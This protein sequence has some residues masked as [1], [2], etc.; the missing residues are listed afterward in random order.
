[1]EDHP[2]LRFS[3]IDG[4]IRRLVV[5][6]FPPNKFTIYPN[7]QIA[8][9]DINF[10]YGSRANSFWPLFINYFELDLNIYH[11]QTHLE[12]FKQYLIGNSWGVTDVALRVQRKH[13]TALDSDLIVIEYNLDIIREI[14]NNNPI[15]KVFFTSKWVKS[16]FN[17]IILPHFEINELTQFFTLPSRNGLMSLNGLGVYFLKRK[18]Y[19]ITNTGKSITHGYSINCKTLSSSMFIPDLSLSLAWQWH[20]RIGCRLG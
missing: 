6:S 9:E 16:K 12:R 2:W 8:G 4:H 19:L 18:D 10:F 1:M 14:F 5:G 11:N 17:T 7:R 13:D 15:E 20:V 3:E